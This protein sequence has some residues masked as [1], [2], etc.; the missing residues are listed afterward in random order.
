MGQGPAVGQRI[1]GCMG[2]SPAA[3]SHLGTGLSRAAR[4]QCGCLARE[5]MAHKEP[6]G[7]VWQGHQVTSDLKGLSQ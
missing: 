6:L 1:A 2:A 4:A 3:R 7:L 5:E